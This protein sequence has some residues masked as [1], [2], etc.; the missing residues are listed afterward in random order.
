VVVV[1]FLETK[2][3]CEMVANQSVATREL[4]ISANQKY[5]IPRACSTSFRRRTKLGTVTVV[6]I[7]L[8]RR[9]QHLARRVSLR[10][11]G[12]SQRIV[13]EN[14]A[15]VCQTLLQG[16]VVDWIWRTEK[17]TWLLPLTRRLDQEDGSRCHV[18]STTPPTPARLPIRRLHHFSD[19]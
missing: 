17:G 8:L 3:R 4:M 12:T 16:S 19:S 5:R 1:T 13:S 15:Q 9:V 18:L 7:H 10:C 11:H 14:H 2:V 6:T